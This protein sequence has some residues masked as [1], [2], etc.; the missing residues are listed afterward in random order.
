MKTLWRSI[1][2]IADLP[3]HLGLCFVRRRHRKRALQLLARHLSGS[4]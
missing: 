2:L 3:H 1:Q 4:K